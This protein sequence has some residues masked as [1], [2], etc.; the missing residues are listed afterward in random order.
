MSGSELGTD[1]VGGIEAIAGE[2]ELDRN[3]HGQASV[4]N[5]VHA[6]EQAAGSHVEWGAAVDVA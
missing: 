3:G 4:G 5:H 6:V 2:Q 1:R